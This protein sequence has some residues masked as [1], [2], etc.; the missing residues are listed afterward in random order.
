MVYS[1]RGRNP[2]IQRIKESKNSAKFNLQILLLPL[3]VLISFFL[4]LFL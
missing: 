4:S 1:K 2:K 3:E